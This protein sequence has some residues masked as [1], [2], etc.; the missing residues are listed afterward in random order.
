MDNQTRH[1][2]FPPIDP[3]NTKQPEQETGQDA[4]RA[5]HTLLDYPAYG[6]FLG[7]TFLLCLAASYSAQMG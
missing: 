4:R 7:A 5:H 2:L 1:T 6:A 3:S